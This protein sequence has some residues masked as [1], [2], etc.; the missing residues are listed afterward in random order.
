MDAKTI[1]QHLLSTRYVC[2]SGQCILALLAL[3]SCQKNQGKW[4]VLLR[5][6]GNIILNNH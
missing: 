3:G 2:V 4:F 6:G 5:G 1:P